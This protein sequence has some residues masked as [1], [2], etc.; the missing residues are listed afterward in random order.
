MQEEGFNSAIGRLGFV[1]GK[2][3]KEGKHPHDFYLKASVLHE[4]GGDRDYSLQRVNAAGNLERLDGKYSYGDTWFEL[5]LGG[6]VQ[7]N[8]NTMFYADL[9]RSFARGLQQEVAGERRAE[10]VVLNRACR[11]RQTWER[12][13]LTGRP[14]G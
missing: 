9:E 13:P 1:L 11:L 2:K 3:Q 8:K 7:L 6:N 14:Y 10:L 12:S 4:F 5:G